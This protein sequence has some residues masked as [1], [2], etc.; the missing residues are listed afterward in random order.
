MDNAKVGIQ[1]ISAKV[2]V[3]TS[4]AIGVIS[5]ASPPLRARTEVASVPVELAFES[6]AQ[7]AAEHRRGAD[8]YCLTRLSQRDTKSQQ[9]V[10][11]AK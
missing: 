1:I 4:A 5:C 3:N 7:S 8:L 2:A 10:H 6:D 11:S 9:S